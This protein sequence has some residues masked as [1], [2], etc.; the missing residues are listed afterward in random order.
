MEAG[1]L[2]SIDFPEMK[3]NRGDAA[4]AEEVCTLGL[5]SLLSLGL[6]DLL[7]LLRLL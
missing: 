5:S 3:K 1:N 4:R 6:L 7:H 2:I